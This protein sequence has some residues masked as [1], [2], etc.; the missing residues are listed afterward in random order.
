VGYTVTYQGVKDPLTN[1]LNS[2]PNHS[3]FQRSD[4]FCSRFVR[5]SFITSERYGHACCS[6]RVL[7]RAEL[8]AA[9][10]QHQSF[11][12]DPRCDRARF[13]LH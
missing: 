8:A 1:T 4:T 7:V 10:H 3:L 12:G 6:I 11:A 13:E 2:G 5:M 9:Q